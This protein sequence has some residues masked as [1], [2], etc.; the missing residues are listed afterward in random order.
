[1]LVEHLGKSPKIHPSALVALNAIVCGD[2]TIGPGSRI[3]FGVSVVA[4]DTSIEL[5]E[6]Q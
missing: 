1:M 4:E 2:V 5:G 3:T 6:K